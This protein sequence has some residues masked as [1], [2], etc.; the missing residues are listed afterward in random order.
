MSGKMS[1]EW[2]EVDAMGNDCYMN[3][4]KKIHSVYKLLLEI[5]FDY[6]LD[7]YYG[8]WYAE[9]QLYIV[10]DC[11]VDAVYFVIAR[12][13]HGAIKKVKDRIE[14]AMHAGEYYMEGEE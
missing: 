6:N 13:P 4:V 10:K 5:E 8:I 9:E 12:N 1:N 11:M 2:K 7:P 14:E 3:K